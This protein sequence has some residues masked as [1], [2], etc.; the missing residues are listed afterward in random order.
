[1]IEA[2]E[3]AML[4]KTYCKKTTCP[5]CPFYFDGCM[6]ASTLPFAWDFEEDDDGEDEQG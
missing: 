4:I 5:K 2:I 3:A 6:L 1:M